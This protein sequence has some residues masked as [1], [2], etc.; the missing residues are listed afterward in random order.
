M[1]EELLKG[2]FGV[3]EVSRDKLDKDLDAKVSYDMASMGSFNHKIV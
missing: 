1:K 3:S 2:R